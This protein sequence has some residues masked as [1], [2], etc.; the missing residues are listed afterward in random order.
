MDRYC[1]LHQGIFVADGI[2]I[3]FINSRRWRRKHLDIYSNAPCMLYCVDLMDYSV[4]ESEHGPVTRMTG[5][6]VHFDSVV[7][8]KYFKST[9]IMLVFSNL[10]RFLSSLQKKPLSVCFPD[11][12]GHGDPAKAF[13]YLKSKFLEL[14][15]DDREIFVHAGE[16]ADPGMY[17]FI[18][19]SVKASLLSR[20]L[21]R[22]ATLGPNHSGRS[23]SGSGLIRSGIRNS[24]LP[25]A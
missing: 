10:S 12:V 22:G 13:G 15:T 4:L 18:V 3:N 17:D 23:R 20:A 14:N 16:L 8:S 6:L 11:Y 19:S 5:C 2:S 21:Q 1:V 25:S 7:R 9:S 24:L